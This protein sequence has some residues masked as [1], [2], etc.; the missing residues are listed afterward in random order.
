M[1]TFRKQNWQKQRN[2]IGTELIYFFFIH[3]QIIKMWLIVGVAH[4]A[5]VNKKD[6]TQPP[7]FTVTTS[8][9][10][11]QLISSVQQLSYNQS[12]LLTAV[13]WLWLQVRHQLDKQWWISA[14]SSNYEKFPIQTFNV[15]TK[16]KKT[17]LTLYRTLNKKFI[18]EGDKVFCANNECQNKLIGFQSN[19]NYAYVQNC[20]EV[21]CSTGIR[22]DMY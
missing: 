22:L 11:W 3:L 12:W 21:R 2:W 1:K 14:V 20:T 10:T 19:P 9:T 7:T 15:E 17:S 8:S 4:A 6:K 5:A 13:N 16:E 18:F